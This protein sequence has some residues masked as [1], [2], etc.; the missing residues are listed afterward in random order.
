MFLK[1][2]LFPRCG[3]DLPVNVVA[4]LYANSA[5]REFCDREKLNWITSITGFRNLEEEAKKVDVAVLFEP[6]GH[7]SVSLS[8]ELLE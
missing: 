2:W 3:I 6:N 4:T 8:P 1:T 5:T 7:F